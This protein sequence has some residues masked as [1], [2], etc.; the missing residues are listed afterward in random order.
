MEVSSIEGV[1]GALGG[2]LVRKLAEGE[3]LW[4]TSVTVAYQ[5]ARKACSREY[6]SLRLR[7]EYQPNVHDVAGLREELP[8]LIL[9]RL[10][11]QVA[12]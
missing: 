4:T 10:V 8:Q 1:D 9:S 7:L 6:K 2:L 11:W 5:T 12:N 3:S